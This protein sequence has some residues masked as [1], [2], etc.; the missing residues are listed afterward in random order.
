MAEIAGQVLLEGPHRQGPG[1]GLVSATSPLPGLQHTARHHGV[2]EVLKSQGLQANQEVTFLTDGGDEVRALTELV[3]PAAEHV[4]DWFHITMRLTVL[5]QYV[6]G[7]TQVDEWAGADLSKPSR[8]TL[9]PWR[10]TM[11]TWTNLFARLHPP[12]HLQ[13]DQLR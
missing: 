12:Q 11:R 10:W 7:V 1:R 6:C 2:F 5:G 4:H 9:M 3:N 8:Q 13:P